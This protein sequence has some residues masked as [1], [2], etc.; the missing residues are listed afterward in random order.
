MAYRVFLYSSIFRD[1][2]R[3]RLWRGA[4]IT[5]VLIIQVCHMIPPRN[6]AVLR[7][8]LSMAAFLPA[9]RSNHRII[10]GYR[11]QSWQQV[12]KERKLHLQSQKHLLFTHFVKHSSISGTKNRKFVDESITQKAPAGYQGE[13]TIK[14]NGIL[15]PVG[16]QIQN[17]RQNRRKFAESCS[18]DS[19]AHWYSLI[20]SDT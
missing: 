9:V 2:D 1:V 8:A 3:G 20:S 6:A 17:K 14:S 13:S 7:W 15:C 12:A 5:S 10:T 16:F 19:C 4:I 11:L 18:A